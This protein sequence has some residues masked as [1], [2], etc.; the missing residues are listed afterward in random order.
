I[1]S[2]EDR[3]GQGKDE[4]IGRMIIPVREV[5]PRMDSSKLPD[6]RWYNLHKPSHAAEEADK[7]KEI[8]FSSKIHL[9][10][11]LEAGY[12]VLDESTPFSSDFQ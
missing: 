3:V 4:A 6:A 9:R 2:V 8:K 7:K 5:P 12:H 10:V 1:V 11:Y